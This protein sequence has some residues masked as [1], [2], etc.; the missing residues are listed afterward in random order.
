M[1]D[2]E[3]A[4]LLKDVRSCQVCVS[5][6]KPKPL[7]H[8][9]RPVLRVSRTARICIAGQAPGTR[10]HASGLPFDDPSGDRLREWLGVDRDTFYDEKLF[11]IVPM[12]FCFPGLDAKGG[13]LPPRK[14]CAPLW[15]ERVFEALPNVKLTLVIGQYAQAWHLGDGKKKTLT[16]TV[17]N[18]RDYMPDKLALPH[19][20]WRNNVWLK[21]NAWFEDDV[22]P[23][24]RKE[25]AKHLRAARKTV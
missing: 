9:P 1:D 5:S 12:G 20:S 21:K 13:D 16:E 14:E 10:V 17:E 8:K 25:V 6:D 22:L 15:R 18:W 19:P 11:A 3:V 7:P 2:K 24:L 4:K 23:V